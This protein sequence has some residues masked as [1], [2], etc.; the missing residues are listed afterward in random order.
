MNKYPIYIVSKNRWENNL[1]SKSSGSGKSPNPLGFHAVGASSHVARLSSHQASELIHRRSHLGVDKTRALAHTTS[2]A[3]K[4][5]ASACAVP[6]CLSCAL[7]RIKRT[8]HSGTLSA[9]DQK[10]FYFYRA[11]GARPAATAR[12]VCCGARPTD[13]VARSPTQS[14]HRRRRAHLPRRL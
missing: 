7:A 6:N 1:T 8:S 2:D 9:P 12:Q 4:V 13:R 14:R 10:N 11:M 5:L 3:P